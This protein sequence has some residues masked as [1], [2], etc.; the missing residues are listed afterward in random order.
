MVAGSGTGAFCRIGYLLLPRFSMM[1]FTAAVEPLRS[2]NRLLGRDHYRWTLVSA[3]GSA[4]EASNDIAVVP[5]AGTGDPPDFDIVVVCAGLDPLPL[6]PELERR[7]AGWLRRAERTG[8][9]IGAIGTGS[10]LLARTG[11]LGGRRCTVHWEHLAGFAEMFQDLDVTANLFEI[12]RDR[13]TC[14][15]GAA[16]LD[17]A[18]HMIA[19]D[20]DSELA[21]AVSEQFLHGRVRQGSEPQRMDLRQRVGV[22]HP[23]LLAAIAEIEA[24]LAE[25]LPRGELGRRVGLSS[26]QL[27]RL[28]QIYLRCTPSRYYLEARLKHARQLLSQTS[29]SVLEVAVACGFASASHFAKCYRTMFGHSPR[30]ER[31]ASA[32]ARRIM[33]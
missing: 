3:D 30:G 25:P 27:E 9:R 16:P 13:F 28:F 26:R 24:N 29:L 8:A 5:H 18:L 21:T 19:S 12:D 33:W 6:S 2:A 20:F 4:V 1:S 22:S 17:L 23:K 32:Q 15:G 7:A 31:R 11:L 14:S 10:F